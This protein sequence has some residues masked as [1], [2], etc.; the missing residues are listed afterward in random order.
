MSWPAKAHIRDSSFRE[1]QLSLLPCNPTSLRHF[2]VRSC[3]KLWYVKN[4]RP[5]TDSLV[6]PIFKTTQQMRM[7]MNSQRSKGRK[8]VVVVSPFL[9]SPSTSNHY[10]DSCYSDIGV[11]EK[12][13]HKGLKSAYLTSTD[14]ILD[15]C[16]LCMA[17]IQNANSF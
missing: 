17:N 16:F 9:P 8:I 3:R 1:W 13:T 11:A 2:F 6:M 7:R 10:A 12:S 5:R 14:V 15:Q 4:K